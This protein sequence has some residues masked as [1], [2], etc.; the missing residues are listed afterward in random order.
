M[1]AL[2]AT[3]TSQQETLQQTVLGRDQQRAKLLEEQ[4]S[5]QAQLSDA[6]AQAEQNASE[7][8][9]EYGT[10]A[11]LSEVRAVCHLHHCCTASILRS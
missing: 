10:L 5:L 9:Q 2:Q 6:V 7:A 11:S 3:I 8:R 1:E 4:Q